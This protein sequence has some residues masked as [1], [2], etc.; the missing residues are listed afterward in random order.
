[1]SEEIKRIEEIVKEEIKKMNLPSEGNDEK[2]EKP[3]E[4]FEC[5]DCGGIVAAL[6]KHCPHCGVGLRWE[7]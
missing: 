3:K 4:T 1:M 6:N 5:P 2:V 7:E